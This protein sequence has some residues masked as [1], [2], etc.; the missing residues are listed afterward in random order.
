M[1][2]DLRALGDTDDRS[3]S[4]GHGRSGSSPTPNTP[5][6]S[7]TGPEDAAPQ[8]RQLVREPLPPPHPRRPRT[9]GTGA[10]SDREARRRHHPAPARLAHPAHRRRRQS[11]SSDP[12]LDLARPD[13]GRPA[14]PTRRPCANIVILRDAYCVFPGCR[15]DSRTCDLD[16]ITAYLPMNDGGPPGQTNPHEPRAPV[17]HAPPR[18]DLHRLGLQAPPTNGSYTWTAPTG[19]QYD[20]TPD[21][22]PSTTTKNLTPQDPGQPQP[23]LPAR[24]DNTVMVHGGTRGSTSRRYGSTLRSEC[25]RRPSRDRS[26]H[27]TQSHLL[28]RSPAERVLP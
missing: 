3:T 19:H 9:H 12:V 14:R 25:G 6:T 10:V 27:S 26:L 4:A 18:Q 21:P 20:V 7:S 24:L 11:S 8:H 2:A 16:H 17:P 1:A 22:T 28:R 23:G 15:R 13:G 5:W